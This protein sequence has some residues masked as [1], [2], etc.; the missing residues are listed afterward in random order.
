MVVRKEMNVRGVSTV[1]AA[2]TLFAVTVVALSALTLF[3]LIDGEP[4]FSKA[5][6]MIGAKEEMVRQCLGEP[7]RVVRLSS[8]EYP[9]SGFETPPPILADYALV[10]FAE[11]SAFYC[12]FD[13]DGTL[14]YVHRSGT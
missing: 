3:P 1:F 9:I 6:A 10:Y 13:D 8:E 11:K 2:T 4:F 5:R 14:V 12:F 7:A